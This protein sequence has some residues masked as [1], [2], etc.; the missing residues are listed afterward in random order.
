MA[1]SIE[2][3]GEAAPLNP[4]QV[5]L[6][7]QSAGSSQ[8]LAIQTGTQQLEA[9]KT[10]RG[11]YTLLQ[12][13]Y[14]DKSLPSEIRY[15]AVIQLKNGIDKYWRK[16]ALNAMNAEEKENIRSRLLDSGFE[17]ADPQL[18]LQNAL[19]ISKVV[20][21]DY[22][23]DW[24]DVLTNLIRMLR[25]ANETNQLHLRRGMLILLQIVKELA[26]ARLR[27]SQTSLQS[28]TPEMVFLLGSIYTQKVSQWLS[29]FTEKSL[30]DQG[31][32]LDAMENSLI[33]I[34]ILRRLLIVGYEYPNHDKDVQQ[35][36]QQSQQ[37]FGQLLT[38]VN[39]EPAVLASPAK[40]LA[41][42]HLVQFAKLH[43]QMS[44]THPAA[45][46]LLPNSIDLVRAYWGFVAKFGDSYGSET[47]DF[48]SEA[49][50]ADDG[51]K[52][53][54]PIMEKLC[55]KG[56]TL[57]RACMKMAFSPTQSFK[58]RTAEVKEEQQ[59]AVAF[60]KAQLLTEQLVAEMASVIVTKFFVFRQVDLESWEEDEDEW[61]IR[62]EGGGDTWEFE[63]RPCA[64]KLF[65]DLVINFKDLLMAPL[66][67]YF[68][69][70]TGSNG[71]SVVTKDAVYTAMG[72]S[73]AVIHQSFDFDTFL[74]STL[75]NDVRQTGQGWK[76]LRRRIAILLG[77]WIPVKISQ[78]NRP[79][80]YQ[81]FQHLLNIEDETNDHVVRITAARQFKAVVDDFDFQVESFLPYAPNILGR[82][83]DLIQEVANTETKLMILE[84]I[85]MIAVRLDTHISPYAD[86]IVS[87]LPAL[88]EASGEE[89][90][91]KQAILTIMSTLVTCMQGKSERYHLL[92]LPLI[93]RAV[94]PGSEMQVYLMEEALDLWSQILAQSSSPA[95]PEVL[96]LVD[97]AFPLLEIGSDNLRMVL[98]IVNQYILLAPETMLGD[99]TRLRILLHMANL[100]GVT[101]RDLAG[102]VTTTVEDLIRAA[103][104][105]GGS[106]GVTQIT[107]DL[108]ESGYTEKIFSGLHDAWE[109]HQ[110]TGPDRK[111]PK[112]DDVVETDY[113][114]ILARIALADPAVFANLLASM[115]NGN[116]EHIWKWLSEEWFRHFD[117]M[118]NIERQKLSCLALTRLL[119]LPPPMTPI[120]LSKLQDFFAMWTSV[121]NEMMAGRDDIG[122]DNLIWG[123][124]TPYAGESQEDKRKREWKMVDPIHQVNT[125]E[126]V[127]GYL[128]EVVRVC[129][130]EEIFQR[131][132]AVNVD[133]DVL[134]GWSKLGE[135]TEHE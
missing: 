8:Q 16:T 91:L 98:N 64:E 83:M 127:K 75:D 130:G 46:V 101:K 84:T 82:T 77:Q 86:E 99:A 105:L 76:V 95:S 106:N 7:L 39:E 62:E 79:L 134:D 110:T 38:I 34:K 3:P 129:G 109:A 53:D 25:T 43:V 73:A 81:I 133:R 44:N 30:D 118:A 120:I 58:Y 135:K 33:A 87:I 74:T 96:A 116:L 50:A 23:M 11:Y 29:F 55:L 117:S 1:F 108:H 49:L 88:W 35:L 112:L 69:S 115:D 68:Q 48:S 70:V 89:H 31:G 13:V 122:G 17:E 94:E 4:Q 121:I 54:R 59:Q 80:V 19:V 41:E 22:P 56:L 52:Q 128:G 104:K 57:L 9:W 100:L 63:V 92:I 102:I 131:D 97:C 65:M 45:F 132:W 15:L 51:S 60:L 67:Q 85:R 42:K 113:F 27:R 12:A 125:W 119:E 72:L 103:E 37:Q 28:V 111:Y 124:Q 90:L 2:V 36:W 6:A 18:A 10:Q 40:E 93:Q 78:A 21:V 107:K 14:L 20:R 5:Y 71:N 32:A 24:P 123:E 61:E 66:L 114:T 126:V 26:T 47:H